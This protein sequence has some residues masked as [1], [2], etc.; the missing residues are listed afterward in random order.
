MYGKALDLYRAGFPDHEQRGSAS[1]AEILSR[2]DYYFNLIYEAD[3]FAGLLPAWETEKFIIEHF[4]VL[5]ELRNR[6]YGQAA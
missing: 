6:K 2:E 1:Q 4:C 5:P 3:R